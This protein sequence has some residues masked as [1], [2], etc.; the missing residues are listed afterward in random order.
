MKIDDMKKKKVL[1][2]KILP[3]AASA[4]LLTGCGA[5]ELSSILSGRAATMHT[6]SI[7]A[8]DTVMELQINGD[9]RADELLLEAEQMIRGL[10]KKVSVTDENSEIAVLNRDGSAEVAEDTAAIMQGALDI[11]EKTDGALDISIYPVLRAWGFT[12]GEYQVPEDEEL[13]ELLQNVDFSKIS[14][15]KESDSISCKIPEGMKVDLGSVTKG[16]TSNMLRDYFAENG[17]ESGLINLGGNVQ[18]IGSKPNGEPWK[19]AIKSPFS[20]SSSGVYGVLEASDVAVITSG[21]YERFFEKDGN[22]YWHILDPK[23]GR[24]ARNGLAS[25]TIVGEDGL[26]CDGLSTALFVMG[27]DSAKEFYKENEGFDAIFISED[28]SVA[29]TSGIADKFKLTSEYYNAKIDI[30]H[31]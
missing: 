29:I 30:I 26:L 17:V 20:G 16:Y 13:D 6:S 19:V 7:F 24:P 12:T 5:G 18:C 8:M 15:S 9:G 28:G 3:L 21:G 22:I 2:G 10:E 23:N 14:L 31:R 25:V 4:I 11:C 1:V 27:L